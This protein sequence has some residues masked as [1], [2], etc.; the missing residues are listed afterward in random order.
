MAL[1]NVI[2]VF[3]SYGVERY[4][5]EVLKNML[6]LVKAEYERLGLEDNSKM[7]LEDWSLEDIS[8]TDKH[9][10]QQNGFDCGIFTLLFMT[11]HSQDLPYDFTQDYIYESCRGKGARGKLAHLLWKFAQKQA[12]VLVDDDDES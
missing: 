3:N 1:K 7:I 9:Y 2:A 5:G 6:E 8:P 12:C 4:N 10:Q 11:L